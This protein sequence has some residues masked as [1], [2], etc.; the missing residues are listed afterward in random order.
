MTCTMLHALDMNY[1]RGPG[2]GKLRFRLY[3]TSVHYIPLHLGVGPFT[4]AL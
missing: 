4:I 1:T 3:F 2:K